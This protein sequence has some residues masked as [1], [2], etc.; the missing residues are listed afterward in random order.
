MHEGNYDSFTRNEGV[1][2]QVTR[3]NQSVGG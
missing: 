2:D 3:L 1:S